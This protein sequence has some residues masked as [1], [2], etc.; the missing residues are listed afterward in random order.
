MPATNVKIV[1]KSSKYRANLNVL[2]RRIQKESNKS[3]F[4]NERYLRKDELLQKIE[5]NQLEKRKSY[6]K[7]SC[8]AHAIRNQQNLKNMEF[9]LVRK[10]TMQKFGAHSY[11]VPYIHQ[12]SFWR[13]QNIVTRNF[14]IILSE[15]LWKPKS[16][17]NTCKLKVTDYSKKEPTKFIISL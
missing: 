10:R 7:I 2:R 6:Q 13:T 3:Q 5:N 14:A 17:S 15:S 9:V 12:T 8:L 4:T 16:R 11:S 1:E